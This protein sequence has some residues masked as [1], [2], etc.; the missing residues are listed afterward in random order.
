MG[1]QPTGGEPYTS[2]KQ[3]RAN[4]PRLTQYDLK[5]ERTKAIPQ[6]NAESSSKNNPNKSKP[7]EIWNMPINEILIGTLIGT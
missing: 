4:A 6:D 2:E 7:T 5:K 3:R 1:H